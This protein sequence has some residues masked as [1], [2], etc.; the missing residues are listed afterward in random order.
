MQIICIY[1]FYFKDL[2]QYSH[3]ARVSIDREINPYF[4]EGILCSMREMDTS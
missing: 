2:S 1:L 3:Q 4:R